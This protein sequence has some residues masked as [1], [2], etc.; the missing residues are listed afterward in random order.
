MGARDSALSLILDLRS[1][2]HTCAELLRHM[3]QGSVASHRVST[4]YSPRTV[5]CCE[6]TKIAISEER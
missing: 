6:C 4:Q 3:E 5:L 2:S 1:F